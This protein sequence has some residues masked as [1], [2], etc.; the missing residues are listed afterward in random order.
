MSDATGDSDQYYERGWGCH[1]A[2][3]EFPWGVA[4]GAGRGQQALTPERRNHPPPLGG[5]LGPRGRSELPRGRLFETHIT[6]WR[7]GKPRAKGQEEE[8]RTAPK[9]SSSEP[10][11]P[12]LRSAGGSPLRPGPSLPPSPSPF[13]LAT[14]FSVLRPTRTTLQY[15]TTVYVQSVAT[16]LGSTHLGNKATMLDTSPY[17]TPV[18][19]ASKYHACA[20]TT[21]RLVETLN[22]YSHFSLTHT[23]THTHSTRNG[24][25]FFST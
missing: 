21:Q 23:H 24:I 16:M 4:W 1:I 10:S 7:R 3:R 18:S 17:I 13:P 15:T 5:A 8:V 6:V 2:M 22:A 14:P 20:R 9:Q 19:C 12:P 25:F 11:R